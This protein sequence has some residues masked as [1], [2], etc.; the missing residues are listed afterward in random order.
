MKSGFFL[1][2]I[3]AISIVGCSKDD[4]K[5]EAVF[6]GDYSGIFER[7][8]VISNVEISFDNNSFNGESDFW[9]FPAIGYGSYSISGNLITFTNYPPWTTDF[10][11][12]L[13]LNDEWTFSLN[14]D[15]LVLTK[16]NGDRYLLRRQ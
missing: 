5:S 6:E 2:M 14:K 4:D 1:L 11:W 7:A 16:E 10:D 9:H 8:E 3:L 15:K 13:I 12:S